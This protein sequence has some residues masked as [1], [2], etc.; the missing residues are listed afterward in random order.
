[1]DNKIVKG[2]HFFDREPYFEID[3]FNVKYLNSEKE[4]PLV[5]VIGTSSYNELEDILYLTT[6]NKGSGIETPFKPIKKDSLYFSVA[7]DYNIVEILP[8]R[9][10]KIV[11]VALTRLC[12]IKKDDTEFIVL[13]ELKFNANS[14]KITPFSLF[15]SIVS[16]D[17]EEI[18]KN[19]K[20]SV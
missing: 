14:T 1:M 13:G 19:V 10:I 18:F 9:D 20:K 16:L 3:I 7:K 2:V 6:N 17:K 4:R 8:N 11:E 15:P 12:S 5:L